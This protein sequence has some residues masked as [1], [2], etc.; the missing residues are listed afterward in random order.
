MDGPARRHLIDTVMDLYVAWRERSASVSVA[1]ARFRDAPAGERALAHAA[2]LAALDQ[3]ER[4]ASE[5]RFAL[6]RATA[7]FH[8]EPRVALAG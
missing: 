5:Y 8:Q 3:E 7:I 1:Y 6:E 2:Y 4:A